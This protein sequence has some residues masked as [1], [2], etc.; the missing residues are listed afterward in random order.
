MII[1]NCF[2]SI[3]LTRPVQ[4]YDQTHLCVEPMIFGR[5]AW[6]YACL[7]S[8]RLSRLLTLSS[9]LV[10]RICK[11]QCVTRAWS[12]CYSSYL[13]IPPWCMNNHTCWVMCNRSIANF[14]TVYAED[15]TYGYSQQFFY[16]RW[17]QNSP[18]NFSSGRVDGWSR[19]EP[20]YR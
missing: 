6:H 13:T 9:S 7:V 16:E 19:T 10:L 4:W 3:F 17:R 18:S 8:A 15:M 2:Y 11:E 5:I 12:G 14:S 20:S 1:P